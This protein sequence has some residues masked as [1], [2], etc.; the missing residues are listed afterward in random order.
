MSISCT[1]ACLFPTA[2]ETD[3]KQDWRVINTN[4]CNTNTL[5]IL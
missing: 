1:A 2:I 4:S 5:V 3:A